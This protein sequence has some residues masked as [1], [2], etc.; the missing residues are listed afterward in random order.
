VFAFAA[1]ALHVRDGLVGG[2]GCARGP[3]GFKLL[4]THSVPQRRHRCCVAGVVDLEPHRTHT[5]PD[6]LRCAEEARRFA[7]SQSR[8]EPSTSARSSV[9]VPVGRSPLTPSSLQFTSAVSHG[10]ISLLLA[11]MRRLHGDPAVIRVSADVC[12]QMRFD[13]LSSHPADLTARTHG[14]DVMSAMPI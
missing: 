2:Q 12:K 10:S 14:G 3:R 5:V 1:A 9:T 6:G 13:N 8:V 7:V 4:L 11:S